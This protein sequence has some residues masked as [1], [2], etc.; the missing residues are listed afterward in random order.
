MNILRKCY[1]VS[2]VKPFFRNLRKE[3]VKMPKIFLLDNGMRNCLLDN[4]QSPVPRLDKGELWENM[5]YRLP[6]H[7]HGTDSFY[8]CDLRKEVECILFCLTSAANLPE[9]KLIKS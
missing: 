8:S 2:L 1:H 7:R 3:L 9:P 5:A 6:N 4:F